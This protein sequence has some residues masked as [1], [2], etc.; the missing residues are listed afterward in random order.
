MSRP[1]AY[2]VILNLILLGVSGIL[3]Q[4][5]IDALE[6]RVRALETPR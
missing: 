3:I 1:V 6:V 5:R 4:Y 2:I